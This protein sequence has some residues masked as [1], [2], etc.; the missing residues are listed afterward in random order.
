M[1]QA[2]TIAGSDSSGGAGI[3]ADIK[4]FAALGVYGASVVTAVTAQNTTGISHIHEIPPESVSAQIDAVLNDL[5]VG[6]VKTGM[7]PSRACICLVAAKLREAGTRN[8]VVDP[9]AVA[10]SGARLQSPGAYTV[11]TG[12]LLPLTLLIT[13][14]VPEAEQLAGQTI[15]NAYDCAEAAR[16]IGAMGPRYVLITGGHWPGEPI[17]YLYDGVG[18]Q[19]LRSGPRVDTKHT[20]GTGCT[21]SAAIVAGLARGLSVETAVVEAKTY[22]TNAL[23]SAFAIGAGHSPVHHF[24]DWWLDERHLPVRGTP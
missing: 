20:H 22:V 21:L 8:V 2:L 7:L 16:V 4:T 3:Q 15:R 24:F 9:V 6:A 5:D 12:E 11:L 17:D 18:T 23:R 13:P 10:S 1:F 14:N 19:A